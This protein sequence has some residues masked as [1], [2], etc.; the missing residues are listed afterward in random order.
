MKKL[1]LIAV[2]AALVGCAETAGTRVTIDTRTGDSSV[3]ECAPRIAQRIK[4]V[5]VSYS[6]VSEGIQR[7]TVTI[8]SKA[9]KR[10]QYQARMIWLDAEGV[11]IDPDSKSFRPIVLDGMDQVSISGVAPNSK[12]VKAKLQIRVTSTAQ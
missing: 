12:A 10:L 7:A 3:V 6:E 11:E 9:H 1:M 4:V 2:A 8:E 5:G